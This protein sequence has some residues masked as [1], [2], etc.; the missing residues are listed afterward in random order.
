MNKSQSNDQDRKIKKFVYFCHVFDAG[1]EKPNSG[2]KI[3]LLF[4]S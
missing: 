1:L 3:R 2:I 4:D